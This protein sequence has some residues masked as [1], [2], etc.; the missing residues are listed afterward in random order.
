V[1]DDPE[2]VAMLKDVEEQIRLLEEDEG[3]FV[4]EEEGLSDPLD[5]VRK[6]F[7]LP[8]GMISAVEEMEAQMESMSNLE[9][10][11]EEERTNIRNRLLNFGT[12]GMLILS[13]WNISS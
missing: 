8:D 10:L 1:V 13:T 9:N 7:E 4:N 12:E 2:E 3:K 6:E 5:H 11:S